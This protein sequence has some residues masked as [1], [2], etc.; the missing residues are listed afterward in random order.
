MNRLVR[1]IL[2]IFLLITCSGCFIPGHGWLVPGGEFPG[3]RDGS[4]GRGDHDGRE[5]DDKD[6]GKHKSHEE[7]H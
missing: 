4:G 7:R 3:D 1:L 2:V 6:R 5:H